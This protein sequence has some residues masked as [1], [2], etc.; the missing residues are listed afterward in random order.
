MGVPWSGVEDRGSRIE[1]GFP[2]NAE[3]QVFV[4]AI[5]DPH[6]QFARFTPTRIDDRASRRYL[7]SL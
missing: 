3:M 2:D 7:T 5:L 6:S 4:F 1:G